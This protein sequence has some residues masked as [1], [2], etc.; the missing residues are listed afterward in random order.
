MGGKNSGFGTYE[1]NTKR[2]I[3]P[4]DKK[5]YKSSIDA[6]LDNGAI[7]YFVTRKQHKDFNKII[8]NSDKK[9]V[10]DRKLFGF[11]DKIKSENEKRNLAKHKWWK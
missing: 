1:Y 3:K 6:M 10:E 5:I 2:K 4:I 11:F 9:A 7:V 8:K